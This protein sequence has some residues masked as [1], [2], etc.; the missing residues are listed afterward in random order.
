MGEAH[1]TAAPCP[2]DACPGGRLP[3]IDPG[4]PLDPRRLAVIEETRGWLRT[5]F[6]P[7]LVFLDVFLT[8]LVVSERLGKGSVTAPLLR[9]YCA[10]MSPC[11]H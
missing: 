4:A 3:G 6:P 2:R 7:P 10:L 1:Q 11:I 9:R 8:S 5:P